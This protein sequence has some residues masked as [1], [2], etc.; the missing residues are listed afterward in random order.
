LV[1][2]GHALSFLSTAWS[3]RF[4]A[5]ISYTT[6]SFSVLAIAHRQAPSMKDASKVRVIPLKGRGKGEMVPLDSKTVSFQD[7]E[8]EAH[9]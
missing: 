5:K 2:G 3:T 8:D 9:L 1:F 4:N 6:V 7:F